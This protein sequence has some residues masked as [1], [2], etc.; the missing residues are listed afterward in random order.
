VGEVICKGN[1]PV[2]LFCRIIYWYKSAY[3]N[4]LVC[5]SGRNIYSTL[6]SNIS[7]SSSKASTM[8]LDNVVY[9]CW[10]YVPVYIYTA[11]HFVRCF[12]A[13]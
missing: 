8:V 9:I 1:G 13:G 11:G 5:R 6:V 7:A 2:I 12:A 3:A 10:Y 4:I